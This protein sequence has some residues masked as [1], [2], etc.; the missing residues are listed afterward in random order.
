MIIALA[1][2][3]GWL[4]YQLDVKSAF[5]H[6]ELN[7][8]VYVE[9]PKGYVQKDDP[10]KVYKLKKA[11]YGLKQAPRAWFNDLIFTDNDEFMFLEFKNSMVRELDMNDMGR[12]RYFLGVEVLQRYDGIYISKIKYALEI[13]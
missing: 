3:K 4:V 2:Q 8:E 12:M 6:G 11:L 5:L 1:A 10:Q 13:L 9:Q 7:D